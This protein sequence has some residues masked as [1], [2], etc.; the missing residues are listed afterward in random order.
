M[1]RPVGA[2]TFEGIRGRSIGR[3]VPAGRDEACLAPTDSMRRKLSCC[4][5]FPALSGSGDP[6][7]SAQRRPTDQDVAARFAVKP[8]AGAIFPPLDDFRSAALPALPSRE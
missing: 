8:G 6:P 7:H 5:F 4:L 1:P 3:R 2:D